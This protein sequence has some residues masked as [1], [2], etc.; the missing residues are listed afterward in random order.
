[1]ELPFVDEHR[2][3]VA[4]PAAQVWPAL[5]TEVSHGLIAA[6]MQGR[7]PYPR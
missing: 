5:V 1:M 4:A 2:E 6:A 3:L 7:T